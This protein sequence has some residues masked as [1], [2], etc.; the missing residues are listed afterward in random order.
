MKQIMMTLLLMLLTMTVTA[1]EK[2]RQNLREKFFN[3][4]VSELVYRLDMTEEQKTKFVPVYRQYSDEMRAAW[5]E[6]KK[7][8]KPMTD[9]DRLARTK[10]KMERQQ[11][12]QTIR[13]KYLDEFSKV[14]TAEQTSRFFEVEGKIQKKLMDRKQHPK[15]KGDKDAHKG[16]K[17]DGKYTQK[18]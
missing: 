6:H 11:K 13:L 9:E 15:C 16:K 14:L 1:Q 4:K 18:K 5:G 3:A 12:V 7:P 8:S 17:H 10:Q 2:G